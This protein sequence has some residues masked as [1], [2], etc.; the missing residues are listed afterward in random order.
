MKNLGKIFFIIF[1]IPYVLYAG[2]TASVDSKKVSLGDMVTYSLNLSGEEITRPKIYNICESDVISTG[3]STNI[4]YVNG[5]YKK[6]Y[7]L[8]YKF[9][10]KKSCKIESIDV[11]IDDKTE[12]TKEIEIEVSKEVSSKDADFSLKLSTSKKE[13]FVG[14]PFELT[15]TVRQK[16]SAEAVDNKFMPPT[17]KGFW[18]KG[19]SKPVRI[20][21]DDSTVT[22]IVYTMAPQ[23]KGELGIG[24]AQM[25]IA[26]RTHKRDSWGGFIPN[27]KWKTYF[28]NDL[29]ITAKPL[30]QGVGLVGDFSIELDIQ[31]TDVNANEPL[32]IT[33]KVKGKGNLEDIKTFKPYIDGVSIF[34]E[35]IAIQNEILTQKIAFVGDS[36]FTVP[37]FELK[38]FNPK[39]QEIKTISTKAIDIKVK[40]AKPKKE[41]NIKREEQNKTV[42]VKEVVKKEIDYLWISL[43]FVLGTVIGIVLMLLKPSEWFKI[44]KKINIKDEKAL[45]IKLLPYKDDKEVQEIVDTI[46]NNIYSENK[47]ELNKKKVKELIK[48]YDIV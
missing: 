15:L 4:Q 20:Q 5:S 21:E 24:S 27:I 11:E 10:P 32:N 13:V 23:R 17:L 18:V 38:F 48:K 35:K 43:A 42:E 6:S 47:K 14:E 12:K 46:E 36:D 25:R 29:N 40:N 31:N 3:S 45:L 28:S 16:N 37:A 22:K 41:L 8:T 7:V 26:S 33:I 30:P 34:D 1:L 19:E 39:T 44:E 9:M 2:V